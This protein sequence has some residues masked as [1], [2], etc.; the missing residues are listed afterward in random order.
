MYARTQMIA[1]HNSKHAPILRDSVQ[2]EAVVSSLV[3]IPSYRAVSEESLTSNDESSGILSLK[4]VITFFTDFYK[5]P[6][7]VE[8]QY[9]PMSDIASHDKEIFV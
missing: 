4:P 5:A 9:I 2:Q 6:A 8:K 7:S 3:N 1:S